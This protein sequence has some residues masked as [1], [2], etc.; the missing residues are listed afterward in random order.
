MPTNWIDHPIAYFVIMEN[1][2]QRIAQ[3]YDTSTDLWM[4]IWGEHM[5]QG[6][7]GKEGTEKKNHL[8][9][10]VDL[11]DELLNWAT[12]KDAQNILDAGCGV[13]GSARYLCLKYNA[14]VTGY[15]L[16]N[17]QAAKAEQ[18]NKLAG[19]EHKIN[20]IVGDMLAIKKTDVQYDLIWSLECAEHI[21]DKEKLIQLFYDLL[22][23]GGKLILATWCRR[24]TPPALE[25]GEINLLK[26][27]YSNYHLPPMIA[28]QDYEL[29]A[30]RAGFKNI[31][32]EDW[33][34]S[35]VPFWEAVIR[36]AIKWK[37]VIGLLRAGWPALKGALA[38][39]YMKNGYRTGTIKFGV[40]QADKL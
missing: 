24:E 36:S 12:I 20:V 34:N 37:S 31:R 17:V 23:P 11:I 39:K 18:L 15:T 26:K 9:A 7:Y 35:V 32:A 13:G 3:F 1:I 16:S 6:F 4:D 21:P 28:I 38:L 29:I 2:N 25:I 14:Q 30:K 27:V 19:L 5:H 8:Q 33:S 40:L 10:Q 22:K